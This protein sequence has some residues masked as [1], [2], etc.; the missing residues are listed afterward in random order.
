MWRVFLIARMG[1][2]DLHAWTWVKVAPTPKGA[3]AA[4]FIAKGCGQHSSYQLGTKAVPAHGDVPWLMLE[5][6]CLQVGVVHRMAM[7]NNHVW[8][9]FVTYE[10]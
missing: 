3:P 9:L 4:W 5:L 1:M 7:R 8:C 2:G 6:A 10:V